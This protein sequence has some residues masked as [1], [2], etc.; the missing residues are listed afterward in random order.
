MYIDNKSNSGL[1]KQNAAR[2]TKIVPHVDDEA[3][4][5]DSP[6]I[7]PTYSHDAWLIECTTTAIYMYLCLTFHAIATLFHL[8]FTSYS[9]TIPAMIL[10]IRT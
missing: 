5:C 3:L 1:F 10:R 8:Y 9:P 4:M 7:G 6:Q 2:R